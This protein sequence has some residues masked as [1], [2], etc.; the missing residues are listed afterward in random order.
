MV[1][2][3]CLWIDTSFFK[4]IS[5]YLPHAGV[6]YTEKNIFNFLL[7]YCLPGLFFNGYCLQPLLYI[8]TVYIYIFFFFFF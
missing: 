2:F 3:L 4:V 7:C 6:I 1:E 8:Y 5:C